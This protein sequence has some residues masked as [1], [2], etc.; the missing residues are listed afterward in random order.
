MTLQH[1]YC[2]C[3]YCTSETIRSSRF[4]IRIGSPSQSQ[5]TSLKFPSLPPPTCHLSLSFFSIILHSNIQLTYGFHHKIRD[6][7]MH[8]LRSIV[9]IFSKNFLIENLCEH[10]NIGTGAQKM[11]RAQK[12]KDTCI[13]INRYEHRNI[14][15][16]PQKYTDASIETYG[17]KHRNIWTRVQKHT[18]TS[19]QKH[20]A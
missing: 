11:F 5:P 17:H 1:I 4:P 15:T 9:N 16:R 3:V 18:G 20:G 8:N 14:G 13:E 12:H 19:I 10:R 2:G 7:F 6:I